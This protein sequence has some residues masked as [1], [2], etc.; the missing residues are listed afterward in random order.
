MWQHLWKRYS[1]FLCSL[2]KQLR[3]K[4]DSVP[5]VFLNVFENTF[6]HLQVSSHK[7]FIPDLHERIHR[8]LYQNS[9]N[10]GITR[11]IN[12]AVTNKKVPFEFIN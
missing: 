4:I 9:S 11:I 10:S 8:V 1:R 7:Y 6:S 2:A 12:F 3:I 5:H